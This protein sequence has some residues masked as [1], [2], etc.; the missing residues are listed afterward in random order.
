[1]MLA[2]FFQAVST[3]TIPYVCNM[4]VMLCKFPLT[5]QWYGAKELKSCTDVALFSHA[6]DFVAS[7]VYALVTFD[8]RVEGKFWS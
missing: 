2:Y 6:L 3:N 8:Y 5:A 7:F 4:F 1:M